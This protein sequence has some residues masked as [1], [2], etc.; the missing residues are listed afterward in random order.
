MRAVVVALGKIGLPLAAQIARAGHEVVGCDIDARR[1]RA[2]QRGAARRSPARPASTRRWPRSSATGA[3][4][5]RPTRRRPSPTGAG[6]RRRRAAAGR[7]RRRARPDWGALDAVVADIGAGLQAGHDGRRSRRRCPSA[8]RATASRPALE[9]RQ[10]P[11]RRGSDFFVASSAPSASTA[12][13]SS[14]DLATYPKLVGGLSAAGEARGVELYRSVPRRRGLAD[15]LR[16]GGR[17]DEARRDDLP[18]RQ[19]RAAPT[20]SRATPTRSASTST[21][22]STPPTRQPFSHIH[23]PGRR[24]RRATAS[25]STRA[26]TSPATP[27][28]A[29]PAAARE[30]NEAMP[31]YAVELL[32][33][34]LGGPGRRAR[35]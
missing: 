26:S 16:R 5:R 12:G 23:R 21:A 18:R 1:R 4:A 10:R 9:R 25:R 30:V 22:S 3:C 35:R 27:T 13:A 29:C 6:P 7:R 15:G 11:A 14:R 33:A 28:R 2:G 8:R 32:E 24:G 34:E 20:S 19:H 31:A 17:A